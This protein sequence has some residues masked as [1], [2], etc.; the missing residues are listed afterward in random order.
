[1]FLLQSIG[2]VFDASADIHPYPNTLQFREHF[3]LDGACAVGPYLELDTG[4]M[5]AATALVTEYQQIG[6]SPFHARGVQTSRRALGE[7]APTSREGGVDRIGRD[8]GP[9]QKLGD[10]YVQLALTR[11]M[12]EIERPS[13]TQRRAILTGPVRPP[14]LGER[15]LPFRPGRFTGPVR[16]GGLS[17]RA[18]PTTSYAC[19]DHDRY[20]DGDRDDGLCELSDVCLARPYRPDRPAS[21]GQD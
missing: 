13:L 2:N 5:G 7:L 4:N 17:C 9:V 20:P 3:P 8:Q 6:H 18:I 19:R 14:C 21:A 16:P 15:R 10:G 11:V 1:M 12:R